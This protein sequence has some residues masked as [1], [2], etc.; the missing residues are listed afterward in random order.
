MGHIAREISRYLLQRTSSP[1]A[2]RG[3]NPGAVRHQVVV[4]VP[5]DLQDGKDLKWPAEREGLI[6]SG[7]VVRA[8]LCH[9]TP[10]FGQAPAFIPFALAVSWD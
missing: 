3:H 5:Y 9:R 8:S 7:V 2:G 10:C 1:A 6:Q 4:F